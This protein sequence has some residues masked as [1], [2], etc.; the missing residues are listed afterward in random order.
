[1]QA[2]W[3][4]VCYGLRG[5]RNRPAFTALAVLTLGLGIG[6]V[7]TIFSSDCWPATS[8]FGCSRIRS[9]A[10]RDTTL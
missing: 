1:M 5:L 10:F 7:T 3:Q 4:D 6:A 8:H 2:I 9:G